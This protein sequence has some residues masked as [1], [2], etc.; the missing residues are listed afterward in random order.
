MSSPLRALVLV[1]ALV[2]VYTT[3]FRSR[4]NAYEVV[5]VDKMLKRLSLFFFVVA[6]CVQAS[7]NWNDLEVKQSFSV[8]R[9]RPLLKNGLYKNSEFSI[10]PEFTDEFFRNFDHEK[11]HDIN[12][13]WHGRQPGLFVSSNVRQNKGE[14]RLIGRYEDNSRV[15]AGV[16]SGYE[17]FT[18]AFV[19]TRKRARYGYFEVCVKVGN[20]RLSSSF[21]MSLD[22][23]EKWTEIDVFEVGGGAVYNGRDFRKTVHMN[24]HVFR[25]VDAGIMPN[26]NSFSV[27]AANIRKKFLRSEFVTFGLDWSRRYITWVIDGKRVR[28][29]ENTH[30]DQALH[31]KFDVETMP[32]WFG[33][34][35]RETLPSLYR[36]KYIRAWSRRWKRRAS[37]RSPT[38]MLSSFLRFIDEP[39]FNQSIGGFGEVGN[40]AFGSMMQNGNEFKGMVGSDR[41]QDEDDAV[42]EIFDGP[43]KQTV[44][45]KDGLQRGAEPKSPERLYMPVRPPWGGVSWSREIRRVNEMLDDVTGAALDS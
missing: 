29:I 13:T 40:G 33:L 1:L 15:F 3:E 20:S 11:W 6:V 21:W 19:M 4:H 23:P 36:I 41:D 14:L 17:N 45:R 9:K 18:T 37:S 34:P 39:R 25:D 30:W 31:L 2:R 26:V 10:E 22:T 27:P 44:V 7:E 24:A 5:F 12:P 35:S 8:R 42:L 38:S 43:A 32:Y 28:R 16:P